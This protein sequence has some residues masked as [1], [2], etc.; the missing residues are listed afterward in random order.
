MHVS[1]ALPAHPSVPTRRSS[2]LTH[3]GDHHPDHVPP[4]VLCRRTVDHL[5]R[6]RVLGRQGGRHARRP[7]GGEPLMYGLLWRALPGRAWFRVILLLLLAALVVY[8]CFTWLFPQ[9][10]PFM[11]FNDTTVGETG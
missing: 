6:A 10:A 3:R 4:A 7:P 8:F 9:I 5:R 2:D 1:S 11:P